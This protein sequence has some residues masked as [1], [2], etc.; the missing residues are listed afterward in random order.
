MNILHKSHTQIWSA[1]K[2][3]LTRGMARPGKAP[4]TA[5]LN[6][7]VGLCTADIRTG[8]RV[9]CRT[10]RRRTILRRQ[11]PQ[12]SHWRSGGVFPTNTHVGRVSR[13]V[14]SSHWIR[15]NIG[16]PVQTCRTIHF[17]N[18]SYKYPYPDI[19]TNPSTCRIHHYLYNIVHICLNIKKQLPFR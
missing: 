1:L 5:L 7:T 18:K 9:R 4:T 19:I 3:T 2:G 6:P 16:W 15:L 12:L 8:G 14:S 17:A 11:H 10:I 13:G